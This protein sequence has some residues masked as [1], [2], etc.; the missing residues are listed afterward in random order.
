MFPTQNFSVKVT[1]ERL[2]D[3]KRGTIKRSGK[4]NN[5]SLQKTASAILISIAEPLAFKDYFLGFV[6]GKLDLKN[7]KPGEH[8]VE[9]GLKKRSWERERE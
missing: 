9:V 6:E 2:L 7:K 4:T 8:Q 5:Y 1:D 3:S